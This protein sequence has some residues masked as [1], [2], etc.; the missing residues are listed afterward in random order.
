MLGEIPKNFSK[1]ISTDVQFPSNKSQQNPKKKKNHEENHERNFSWDLNPRLS[2]NFK[3]LASIKTCFYKTS[4]KGTILIKSVAKEKCIKNHKKTYL[5]IEIEPFWAGQLFLLR[6]LPFT[7]DAFQD[8]L[9]RDRKCSSWRIIDEWSVLKRVYWTRVMSI[10]WKIW[11]LKQVFNMYLE[12]F[13][14][15]WSDWIEKFQKIHFFT[16]IK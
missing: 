5:K 2:K 9:R 10:E 1:P 13:L 12:S 3:S 4:S 8:K 7:E 15:K 16:T 11:Q 14:R 6:H